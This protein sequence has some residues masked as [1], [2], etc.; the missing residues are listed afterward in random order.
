MVRK[1]VDICEK[2]GVLG[3]GYIPKMHWTQ[4]TRELRR[5]VL[6]LSVGRRELHPHLP[7]AGRHRLGLG[8]HDRRQGSSSK[9]DAGRAHRRSPPTRR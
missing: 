7:H 9:I 1:S 5:A 3:A 2:K 8:R 6:L 4:A